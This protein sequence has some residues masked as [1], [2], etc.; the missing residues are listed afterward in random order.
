MLKDFGTGYCSV[1]I[2]VAYYNYGNAVSLGF[3]DKLH[4]RLLY[5]C[6]RSGRRHKLVVIHG[7]N[8]INYHN[9]GRIYVYFRNDLI[10]IRFGKDRDIVS[11]YVETTSA[12]LYL[13]R[14]LLARNI[15][16]AIPLTKRFANLQKQ[17]GL[18]YPRF[19]RQQNNRAFNKPAAQD[20]VKFAYSR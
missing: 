14:R 20:T 6:N 13:R 16:Y 15:Q 5:L 19:S 11:G 4:C 8:G 7:L 1:F 9:I 18:P 3:C 2:D 17:S 10:Y 12:Q